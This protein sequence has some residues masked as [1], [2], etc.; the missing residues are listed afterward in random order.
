VRPR[1]TPQTDV[2][3]RLS[4]GNE[5]N[6]LW[7]RRGSTDGDPWIESVWELDD[8]ERAQ[9]AAGATV[10]LRVYGTSTPP[11]SLAIGQPLDERRR[12][13]PRPDGGRIHG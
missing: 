12:P 11:V 1:R 4:G 2:V 7:V 3:F 13:N 5:D 9:V 8:D 10:E 6:D